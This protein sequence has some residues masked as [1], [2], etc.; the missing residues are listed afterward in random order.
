MIEME[1]PYIDKGECI[2]RCSASI[3]GMA[4]S[5]FELG[6]YCTTEEHY[7]CPILLAHTL[8]E[9]YREN[10]VRAGAILTR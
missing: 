8:R 1:C 3:T 5:E 10:A 4:P 6:I 7:R 9:G 2:N